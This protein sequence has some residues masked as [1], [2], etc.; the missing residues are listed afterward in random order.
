[1]AKISFREAIKQA[2]REEMLS[3]DKV[4][5]IGE[6]M[7]RLGGG[8][9]VLDGLWEEFGDDRVID[10]PIS[11]ALIAGAAVGAAMMGTKPVAELM[12]AD[13]LTL[14]MDQIVNYAAKLR[15]M[16]GGKY[17]CHMV[18]RAPMGAG[19]HYG[20][21]HQQSNEAWFLHVPGLR[22]IAPATPFDAKG[23]M[24]SAIRH[25]DPVLFFEN[26]MLYGIEGEV[27]E[28]EYFV[29]IGEAEV[30]RV[31]EDVSVIA[32]G[33]MVGKALEAAEEL[34]QHGVNAEVVDLRTISPMDKETV[35]NSLAKTRRAV[36]VH[37]GCR[38]GGVGAEIAA[39][40][41]EE[42]FWTLDAPI[43]RVASPDIPVP[44][45][46]ILEDFYIPKAKDIVTA[47]RKM[48]GQA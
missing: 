22:V 21:A 32:Y 41:A 4:F 18:V 39:L 45:A 10:T 16:H 3:D 33:P 6:D 47:V 27:P 34:Q 25:P 43:V 42:G 30:K 40:L 20:M 2:I 44:F 23:L 1:L 19:L 37:E 8:F 31:G 14:A 35:L 12:F 48:M 17:G 15:Y 7:H 38:T 26:K 11:E 46:P 5:V 28:E 24:K 29:G 36:I 13:F 9:S